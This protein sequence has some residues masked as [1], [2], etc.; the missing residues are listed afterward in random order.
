[1]RSFKNHGHSIFEVMGQFSEQLNYPRVNLLHAVTNL[2]YDTIFN[3]TRNLRNFALFPPFLFRIFLFYLQ[4]YA[5]S[6]KTV[7]TILLYFFTYFR[8][9]DN[10][11]S[12]DKKDNPRKKEFPPFLKNF[13]N[14][15]S[16]FFPSQFSISFPPLF[17]Y[18]RV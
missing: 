1:M 3:Q 10:K 4:I 14:H 13:R 5:F 2:P 17:P 15:P 12:K 16:S 18:F 6:E 9:K 11:D 7:K 8:H